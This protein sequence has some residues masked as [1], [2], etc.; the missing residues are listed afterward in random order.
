MHKISKALQKT[1]LSVVG[2]GRGRGCGFV[3]YF[4]KLGK[5]QS[6]DKFLVVINL[7]FAPGGGKENTPEHSGSIPET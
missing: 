7:L 5:E 4:S 2:M 3:L 1:I 6:F